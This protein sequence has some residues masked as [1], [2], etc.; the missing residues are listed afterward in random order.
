M[1][2]LLR[3][4]GRGASGTGY[5]GHA[6]FAALTGTRDEV[7]PISAREV[8]H[9]IYAFFVTLKGE[10]WLQIGKAPDLDRAIE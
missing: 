6:V 10:V 4:E 5:R 8:V 1:A 3:I 7:W 9:A 2:V